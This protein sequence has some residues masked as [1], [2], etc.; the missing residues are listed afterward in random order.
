MIQFRDMTNR[1]K[2]Y[3]QQWASY[4]VNN[5]NYKY[6]DVILN[7]NASTINHSVKELSDDILFNENAKNI[8]YI[9]EFVESLSVDDELI[10]KYIKF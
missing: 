7:T 6:D 1:I 4:M 8:K 10:V 9:L 5:D 2:D 3:I